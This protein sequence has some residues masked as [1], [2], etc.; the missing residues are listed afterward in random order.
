LIPELKVD[1]LAEKGN[2]FSLEMKKENKDE[3]EEKMK[4]D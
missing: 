4:T 3:K 2:I 1:P